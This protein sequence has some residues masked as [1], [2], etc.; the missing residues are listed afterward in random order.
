MASSQAATPGNAN[1]IPS[2][3]GDIVRSTAR[4]S[5]TSFAVRALN[6]LRAVLV[7]GEF[8]VEKDGA[9]PIPD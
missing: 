9:P 5:A 8:F 6:L 1:L 7:L 4:L 3:H 2:V